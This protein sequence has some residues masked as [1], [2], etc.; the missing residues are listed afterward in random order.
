MREIK[1]MKPSLSRPLTQ[2]SFVYCSEAVPKGDNPAKMMS[3]ADLEAQWQKEENEKQ[4]AIRKKQEE[5]EQLK[6]EEEEKKVNI[7]SIMSFLWR[8]RFLK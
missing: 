7:G 5:E 2:N 3:A 6:Q 4:E 1:T 8:S